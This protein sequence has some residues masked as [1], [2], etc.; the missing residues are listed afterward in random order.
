MSH[1]SP[2]ALTD[3]L[4]DA[5]AGQF[6]NRHNRPKVSL[7]QQPMADFLL[8][9]AAQI[10]TTTYNKRV[11]VGAQFDQ[12]ADGSVKAVGWFNGQPYHAQPVSLAYTISA[13]AAHY[14]NDSVSIR[15]GVEPFPKNEEAEAEVNLLVALR[16]GF[17]VGFCIS[18][19]M[20]FLT[21]S[22]IYFL[23]KEKLVG[24][25]HMQV[26]HTTEPVPPPTYRLTRGVA[27]SCTGI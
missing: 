5:Y 17:I 23:I 3:T 7:R 8:S 27:C 13:L 12:L 4:A 25:K 11:I 20:A 15:S 14:V 1:H 2:N 9:T 21:T 24:A 18:I 6:S 16:T 19:G 10:G 26:S 22:F